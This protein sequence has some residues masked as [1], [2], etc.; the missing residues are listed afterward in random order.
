MGDDIKNPI[1]ERVIALYNNL[2]AVKG[3]KVTIDNIEEGYLLTQEVIYKYVNKGKD[4]RST[5][6]NVKQKVVIEDLISSFIQD[7]KKDNNQWSVGTGLILKDLNTFVTKSLRDANLQVNFES[8]LYVGKEFITVDN[9]DYPCFTFE[10]PYNYDV[11]NLAEQYNLMLKKIGMKR[12][13]NLLL[14]LELLDSTEA[15]TVVLQN[16][17]N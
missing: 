13:A 2:N 7:R 16:V 15:P 17:K 12:Y 3:T 6:S 11:A 8:Y 5:E 4:T 1:R 14:I 9:K 10:Y